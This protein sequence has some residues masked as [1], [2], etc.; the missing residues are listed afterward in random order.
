MNA[1][2]LRSAL[3]VGSASILCLATALGGLASAGPAKGIKG[4][5]QPEMKPFTIGA[6][7]SGGNVAIKPNGGLV[8]AYDVGTG[9]GETR[10]CLLARGGHAC[11]HTTSLSPLSGDSTFDVPEVYALSDTH[12]VVLQSTCCDGS[13]NGG[14]L[15]FTSTDG[16]EV[17]GAPVRVGSVG[18]AAGTLIGSSIVFTGGNAHIGAQ[19]ESIS[20]DASGPPATTATVNDN[21]PPDVGIGSYKAGVLAAND[22]LGSDYS[23]HVEYAAAGKNFNEGSSY[24]QVANYNHEYVVAM[25][26]DAL[27]TRQTTGKEELMLRFF[28]GTTF[29]AAHDVPGYAGHTLG[30]SS[31]MDRDSAGV[32]HLFIAANYISPIYDLQ[33][34]STT[35]GAHWTRRTD[36]GNAI[37]NDV[38]GVRLDSI[39]SGLVI[40]GSKAIGYPVLASQRVSFKLK[41]SSVKKGHTTIGSGKGVAKAHGRKVE[42]QIERKG[43]WFDV[44]TT[45]ESSS[46]AFRFRIKGKSVG[47]HTYRA[48]AADRAGYIQFG[49]SVGRTLRVKK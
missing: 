20:D 30:S 18:V 33:E 27:L 41:K 7:T 21:Q 4:S 10:V 1:R 43:R 37:D 25:S 42:L 31:T 36:L 16:G 44:K 26:G 39:G 2:P 15:L 38:F 22:V 12:I 47:K 23:A 46:G 11:T 5:P 8:V 13:T 17:F 6:S 40:G 32:T 35:T 48:V 49:Y 29:G 24:K 9:N 14:D 28:N 45:H 34:I 3:I 19:V